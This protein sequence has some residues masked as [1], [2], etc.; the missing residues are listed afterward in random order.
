MT[1]K[2]LK[3]VVAKILVFMLIVSS[4]SVGGQLFGN[5][6]SQA[7]TYTKASVTKELK[8]LQK[9]VKKLKAKDKAQKKNTTYCMFSIISKK[10]FVVRSEGME[11]KYYWITDKKGMY[12]V[13]GRNDMCE[14]NIKY[15][16]KTKKYK[17]YK[18]TVAKFVK[19]KNYESTISK[20]TAKIKKLNNAL[21]NTV[22]IKGAKTAKVGSSIKLT[23]KKK[24][25]ES[26]N[27]VT[28]KSSDTSIASV[29]K[30]GK[31][32][33]KQAGDVTITATLSISGKKA[34]YK[35]KGYIA[36]ESLTTDTES[37]QLKVGETAKINI[38]V[39]PVESEEEIKWTSSDEDIVTVSSDGTIEA[40]DV[41]EAEITA[42]TTSGAEVTV[43]VVV[44]DA[45]DEETPDNTVEE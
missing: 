10:P 45:D 21:K 27:K 40:I 36:A 38:T 33:V 23:A 42:S 24:Y 17:S 15:T 35:V 31:V 37:Y 6:K 30:N 19:L 43:T 26:Y 39:S 9:E 8:K 13:D 20:K 1:G 11:Q 22:T 14:G 7:A 12:K 4:I 3:R 28:W 34:E 2:G 29:D 16:K 18:C 32:S 44:V 41:G 25:S 5:T